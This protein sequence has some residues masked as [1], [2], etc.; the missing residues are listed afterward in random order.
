MNDKKLSL[1]EAI[2]IR[3]RQYIKQ[4]HNP[5]NGP[6]TF[7]DVAEIVKRELK[8]RDSKL[9]ERYQR[10]PEVAAFIYGGL[11]DW[12]GNAREST[13]KIFMSYTRFFFFRRY[14]TT[15]DEYVNLLFDNNRKIIKHYKKMA[16]IIRI[17]AE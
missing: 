5:D 13:N 15:L 16:K 6:V 14:L 9:L 1:D 17:K 8:F 12:F 4:E 10:L 3:L 11:Y 7:D 2:K